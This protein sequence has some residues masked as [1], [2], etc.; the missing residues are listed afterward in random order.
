MIL[1]FVVIGCKVPA[2][3][4]ASP[5]PSPTATPVQSFAEIKKEADFLITT[6][7][8][9]TDAFSKERVQTSIRA[10]ANLTANAKE[11]KAAADLKKQLETIYKKM[12]D[13]EALLGPKPENSSLD[14]RVD[15]VNDYLRRNLNDY[16]S[17][18]FVSWSPASIFRDS[19]G[20]YWVVRLRLRAKNGFG[21]FVLRDTYYFIRNGTVIKTKG[22]GLD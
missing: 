14:G 21:A 12:A 10:L 13:E 7:K 15:I 8:K 9:D 6:Y 11:S 20:P 1:V 22:L 16:S 19:T 2:D 3:Q 5:T 4:P 17:S 18:E